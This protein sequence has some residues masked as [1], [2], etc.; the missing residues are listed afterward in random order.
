MGL[1]TS[2]DAL[3]KPGDT[4]ETLTLRDVAGEPVALKDLLER[5]L[6]IPRAAATGLGRSA[7]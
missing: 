2:M 3:T 6:V 1:L 7:E 5:P 4:V